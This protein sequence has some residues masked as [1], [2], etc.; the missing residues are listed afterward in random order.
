MSADASSHLWYLRCHLNKSF[1]YGYV[2]FVKM[3]RNPD[4]E[5]FICIFRAAF[6]IKLPS[7]VRGILPETTIPA[8]FDSALSVLCIFILRRYSCGCRCSFKKHWRYRNENSL[9]YSGTWII[10][11]VMILILLQF[12]YCRLQLSFTHPLFIQTVS[13]LRCFKLTFSIR[14]CYR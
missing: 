6:Y 9:S 10:I 5:Q 4:L 8:P 14:P 3:Y 1:P 7:L 11:N 12:M 13:K 2:I